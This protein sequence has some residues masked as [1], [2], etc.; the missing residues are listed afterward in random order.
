MT[1][2]QDQTFDAERALYAAR[3]VLARRCTFDGPADGESAFKESRDIVAEH[4]LFC[5][6]YPFWHVAGL[7]IE[8]SEM[9]ATCRAALWYCERVKISGTKMHGIKALRESR[10]IEIAGSD[11]VSPEFGWFNH[12]VKMEDSTAESEYFMMRS[13]GLAFRNVKMKGKYAFQ[14]IE[15]CTFEACEFDTKDA[16]WHAKNVSVKNS[17]VNGEYLAWYSEN[18]TFENCIITGTQP[19]CYCKGL[20]LINCEM[21]AADLSFE[22]SEV[23][24]TITTPVISVKNPLKG[25]IAA[26]AVGEI[27]RDIE[28]ADGEV[29][30]VGD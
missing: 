15:D 18:L 2:I 21:H 25:K 26:P 23:D 10:D 3:C 14:Y 29:V 16:F 30:I 11:I 5:L 6:R 8:S 4:C 28:G 7:V 17:V 19:L 27:I 24:A 9:T 20:K 13:T 1:V 22:R 12:C